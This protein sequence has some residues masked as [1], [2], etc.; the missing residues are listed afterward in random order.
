MNFIELTLGQ[1]LEEQVRK[2]PDKDFLIYSI[3]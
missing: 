1:V 3:P 2:Y